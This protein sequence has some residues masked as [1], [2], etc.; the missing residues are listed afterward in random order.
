MDDA[1]KCE[2]E[3][4]IGELARA[5]ELNP[6]TLR[7]Y[8]QLGLLRPSARTEAGYRIYTVKDAQRL[9]FIR[10]AQS[11]GLSLAEIMGIISI[12]DAGVTP[13]T[14]VRAL[15]ETKVAEIG[16]RIAELETLREELIELGERAREVEPLCADGSSICLAFKDDSPRCSTLPTRRG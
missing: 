14:H 10:A 16:Q 12:R 3:M 5:A 8:E 11:S 6:R 2:Q 7:Y 4:R 15:A 13:C 1:G 9:A